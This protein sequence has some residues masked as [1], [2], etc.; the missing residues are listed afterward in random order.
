MT[1]PWPALADWADGLRRDSL[2]SRVARIPLTVPALLDDTDEA[3]RRLHALAPTALGDA[4]A[5]DDGTPLTPSS[6]PASSP[7][8]EPTAQV[9][10]PAPPGVLLRGGRPQGPGSG[11]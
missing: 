7:R 9:H 1:R 4:H 11:T 5:L 3:L 8:P 6:W 10:L 2:V